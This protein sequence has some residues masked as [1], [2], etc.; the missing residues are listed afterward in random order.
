MA[1]TAKRRLDG[2]LCPGS[3]GPGA[4]LARCSAS[5]RT[6]QCV[7]DQPA[8]AHPRIGASP[9]PVNIRGH[10]R[11]HRIGIRRAH[12]RTHVILLVTNLH[13]RIVNAIPG[14]LLREL[15]LDPTRD[16]QP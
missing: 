9:D 14:E 15:I 8:T 16:Y 11:L 13:V 2:A 6:L 4:H 7:T 5:L 3:T 10:R 1:T 12:A